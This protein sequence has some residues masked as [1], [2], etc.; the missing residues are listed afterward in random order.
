MS[1]WEY[2]LLGPVF[3]RDASRIRLYKGHLLNIY[4]SWL[5]HQNNVNSLLKSCDTSNHNLY[6]VIHWWPQSFR[7]VVACNKIWPDLIVTQIPKFVGPTWGPPGSCR[8]QMGLMLVPWTMLSGYL[9][10][11]ATRFVFAKYGLWVHQSF[12]NE[13]QITQ[14]VIGRVRGVQ[15]CSKVIGIFFN[16]KIWWLVSMHTYEIFHIAWWSLVYLLWKIQWI[17]DSS[18]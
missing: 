17:Y 10:T 1:K 14:D 9:S 13:S 15:P 5:H 3:M 16:T 12:C 8:P 2:Q 4:L 6:L 18:E 11:R 7:V